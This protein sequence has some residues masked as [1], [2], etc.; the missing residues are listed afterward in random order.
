MIYIIAPINLQCYGD[1]FGLKLVISAASNKVLA[2]AR[3]IRS[4]SG[5]VGIVAFPAFKQDTRIMRFTISL[6]QN[7]IPILF[8]PSTRFSLMRRIFNATY[9]LYLAIF[10]FDKRD[11][12]IL[13]N[14]YPEYLLGSIWLFIFKEPVILDIEDA[15]RAL[16][17][18]LVSILNRLTLPALLSFARKKYI[19]AS[20]SIAQSLSFNNF[21]LIHGAPLDCLNQNDRDW[22]QLPINVLFGGTFNADTGSEIFIEA[23]KILDHDAN[24]KGKLNFFITGYSF[25]RCQFDILNECKN[26]TFNVY[27]DLNT[28]CYREVL[29]KTHIGLNLRNK[30]SEFSRTTFPSKV[31]EYVGSGLLLVTT[32]LDEV[33]SLLGEDACYLSGNSSM[34]LASL[35]R[36]ISL[37]PNHY[38]NKIHRAQEKLMDNMSFNTVG[39]RL[40]KFLKSSD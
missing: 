34:E 33:K 7:D 32:D 4:I 23:V 14:Y 8:G 24:L 36:K 15:P 11:V 20:K 9:F 2:I 30:Y 13:Y 6:S 35:L 3:S 21:F 39:N 37:N 16:D 26:V 12:V 38:I 28:E 1:R 27:S 31:T 18:N 40:C 25:D 19:C 22:S 29:E 10:F 5:E 17:T